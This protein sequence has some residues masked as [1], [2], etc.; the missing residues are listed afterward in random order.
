MKLRRV[1]P[2]PFFLITLRG[3]GI[4]GITGYFLFGPPAERFDIIA[5]YL[6]YG[7]VFAAVYCIG[8]GLLSQLTLRRR[9]AVELVAIPSPQ[10]R[11]IAGEPIQLEATTELGPRLPFFRLTIAPLW[12]H[13]SITH[14]LPQ[15]RTTESGT[16]SATF[17]VI[18][19]HR[20][21]WIIKRFEI[22]YR[23]VL[24]ITSFR[25]RGDLL[26]PLSLPV[27]PPDA[28]EANLPMVTLRR[29]S[30]EEDLAEQ[31]P[32]GES[33]DLKRY[34]PSDG[35]RRIVW[36]IYARS[37]QL[38][39]RHPEPQTQPEGK[40]LVFA[41]ADPAADDVAARAHAY[42]ARASQLGLDIRFGCLGMGQE[43]LAVSGDESL[44]LLLKTV[45]DSNSS[46][47]LADV[48]HFISLLGAEDPEGP[49]RQAAFFIDSRWLT[50]SNE[51]KILLEASQILQ[52]HQIEPVWFVNGGRLSQGEPFPYG[53]LSQSPLRIPRI[54]AEWWFL[55]ERESASVWN[56]K[57]QTQQSFESTLSELG[58]RTV[59]V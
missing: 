56:R 7:T 16:H 41:V 54:W 15:L 6:G 27:Y 59:L 19:P 2:S 47:L 55:G 42:V 35:I 4:L 36:K 22:T 3:W 34:D 57:K 38:I 8:L 28:P 48:T 11:F 18:L 46:L 21:E 23:D 52:S 50:I 20:G 51:S 26:H 30:G 10:G 1:P 40:T 33:F 14:P 5:R 39:A 58:G 17:P 53:E 32:E 45:W 37:G 29:S 44:R 9:M 24:G 25:W 43:P 49:R 13:R 12:P 31:L